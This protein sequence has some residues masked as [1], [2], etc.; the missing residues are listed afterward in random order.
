MGA[1][2]ISL[3][4]LVFAMLCQAVGIF[5]P[6]WVTPDDTKTG[7]QVGVWYACVDWKKCDHYFDAIK[8][9]AKDKDKV[10]PAVLVQQLI[11]IVT[12]SLAFILLCVAVAMCGNMM[13]S[14]RQRKLST[15][16]CGL[17][18]ASCFL[19]MCG[20]LSTVTTYGE[21]KSSTGVDLKAGYGYSFYLSCAAA[22]LSL[23]TGFI[24]C[25]TDDSEE[26]S[27]RNRRHVYPA[28]KHYDQQYYPEY[29]YQQQ[30]YPMGYGGAA[31]FYG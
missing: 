3:L 22:A 11:L 25:C 27:S 29:Q 30:N 10:L 17:S 24:C 7:T 26:K 12:E 15:S 9:F 23:A 19:I 6:G 31:P 4:L 14:G 28:D 2:H 1:V 18:V 16:L 20:V 8:L 5:L 21:F 13:R